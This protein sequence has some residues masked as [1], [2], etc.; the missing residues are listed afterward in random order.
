MSLQPSGGTARPADPAI[1][2]YGRWIILAVFGL[3]VL[4]TANG[5]YFVVPQTDVAY[6]KRFGKVVDPQ[7]GPLQPG[8]H[9][10]VPLIDEPD[11]IRITTDTFE[12]PEKKAFT[13]DTQEIT[14]RYA[15][16]STNK[17]LLSSRRADQQAARRARHRTSVAGRGTAELGEQ[18]DWP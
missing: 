15:F 9:F 16:T 14:L 5:S 3:A 18:I 2:S 4:G 7:G 10:K 17:I 8:L 1:A 11:E 12:L 6:V 13:R